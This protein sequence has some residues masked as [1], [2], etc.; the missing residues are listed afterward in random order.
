M[1]M[2]NSMAIHPIVV[3]ILQSGLKWWTDQHC[4]LLSYSIVAASVAKRHWVKKYT[5]HVE[6]YC[7]WWAKWLVKHGGASQVN[8]LTQLCIHRQSSCRIL[9]SSGS[10]VSVLTVRKGCRVLCN[11]RLSV[12]VWATSSCQQMHYCQKHWNTNIKYKA[13]LKGARGNK[14]V[15]MWFDMIFALIWG[16]QTVQI[17][18]QQG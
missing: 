13:F 17:L 6:K 8:A 18:K 9:L 10:S 15:T 2:P 14:M 16:Q 1:S 7:Q 4:N 12:T 11:T 5:V 3:E